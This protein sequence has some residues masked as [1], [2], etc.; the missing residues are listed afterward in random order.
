MEVNVKIVKKAKYCCYSL[1]VTDSDENV[2]QQVPSRVYDNEYEAEIAAG[3]IKMMFAKV[4]KVN[5]I[6]LSLVD[7]NIRAVFRLIDA[8]GKW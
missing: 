8:P 7:F 6:D 5:Q 2:I 3:I 4:E 1:V